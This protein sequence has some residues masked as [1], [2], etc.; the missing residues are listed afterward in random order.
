MI[1]IGVGLTIILGLGF[2]RTSC[3]VIEES[4]NLFFWNGSMNNRTM[5]KT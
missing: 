4:R 3:F 5:D 2:A 1:P